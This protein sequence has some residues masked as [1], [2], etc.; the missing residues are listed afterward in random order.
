MK[1]AWIGLGSNQGDCRAV[2][3]RASALLARLP[4]TQLRAVSPIYQTAPWGN[5]DQPD[6]LNAVAKIATD[7]SPRDLLEALLDIE[8]QLGRERVGPRWG[9][10]LID[11][12]LLVYEGANLDEPDLTVPHPRMH[13]RAFV[14]VPLADLSP[15]LLVEGQ[16]RVSALLEALDVAELEAVRPAQDLPSCA[17]FDFKRSDQ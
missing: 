8:L 5:T 4:N 17:S 6:F 15:D 7:L 13:Q 16:G 2:L 11:L 14:L 1:V 9:P 12:D 3:R 10:R